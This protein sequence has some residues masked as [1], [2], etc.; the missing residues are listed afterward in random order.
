MKLSTLCCGAMRPPLD[1]GCPSQTRIIW[2]QLRCK[3]RTVF[4]SRLVGLAC[5]IVGVLNSGTVRGAP[6]PIFPVWVNSV[7]PFCKEQDRIQEPGLLGTWRE[8]KAGG[9]AVLQFE[10][11]GTNGY[12]VTLTDTDCTNRMEGHCLKLGGALFVELFTTATEPGPPLPPPPIPSHLLL[13]VQQA[14]PT[15]RLSAIESDW[16]ARFL[17]KSPTAFHHAIV[18]GDRVVL[19]GDTAELRKFVL[20]ALDTTSAWEDLSELS[21]EPASGGKQNSAASAPAQPAKAATEI[22]P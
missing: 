14:N 19:A 1:S 4:L 12:R 17:E 7:H 3:A 16:A 11:Q 18:H 2:I 13:R 21:R 9:H 20:K 5:L 6:F 10:P 15:L 22:A 8:V